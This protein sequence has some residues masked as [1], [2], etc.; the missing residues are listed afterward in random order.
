VVE[1]RRMRIG[2]VNLLSEFAGPYL[3]L[4]FKGLKLRVAKSLKEGCGLNCSQLS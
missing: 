2:S 3:S 4:Y 1:S